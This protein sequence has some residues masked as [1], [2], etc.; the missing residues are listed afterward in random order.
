MNFG[1]AGVLVFNQSTFYRL[2][3]A[4]AVDSARMLSVPSDEWCN[5]GG[6]YVFE[7]QCFLPEMQDFS[8]P[9]DVVESRD[10]SA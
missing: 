7:K 10:W 6:I 5:Q 8:R 1:F 3:A 2:A 9:K 4:T